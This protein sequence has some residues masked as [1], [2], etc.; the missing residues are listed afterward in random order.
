VATFGA[1]RQ[2]HHVSVVQLAFTVMQPDGGFT[3]KNDHELLAS[4]VEVVDE[5]RSTRL[6]LP[7]RAAKRSALC[8]H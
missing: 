6:E 8:S 7:Y 2:R 1:S 4:V 3:A 5:L